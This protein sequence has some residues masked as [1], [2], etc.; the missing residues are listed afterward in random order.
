MN[1]LCAI[2]GDLHNNVEG[3][4]SFYKKNKGK[5]DKF[6][7]LGDYF[8]SFGDTVGDAVKTAQ[9]V[10]YF[11]HQND[12]ILLA[13]NHD[14][15]YLYPKSLKF[16]DCPGFE[17]S[18]LEAIQ[19]ILTESDTNK[20]KFWHYE[21]NFLFTHAGLTNYI[22]NFPEDLTLSEVLNEIEKEGEKAMDIAKNGLPPLSPWFNEGESMGEMNFGG[23][24]WCRQSEFSEIPQLGQIFGHSP[25]SKPF[26]FNGTKFPNI[27]MDCLPRYFGILEN[28]VFK[29]EKFQDFI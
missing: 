26:C 13:G 29:P 5:F 18:K 28:G 17:E 27:F 25:V 10:K 19:R 3:P 8:D 12:I 6:I 23:P 15:P 7:F 4:L 16:R 2:L 9:A 20:I 22:M 11:L 21:Q 1:N 24:F 14:L